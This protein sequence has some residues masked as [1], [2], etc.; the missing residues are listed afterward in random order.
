MQEP[1]GLGQGRPT[2][3]TVRELL[4]RRPYSER[5]CIGF[6]TILSAR[7][8]TGRIS[9]RELYSF[10][11]V[12]RPSSKPFETTLHDMKKILG[13]FNK[14]LILSFTLSLVVNSNL[15]LR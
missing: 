10:P 5:V 1:E 7:K 3:G 8:Y 4:R 11:P 12:Q 2:G 13:K 15:L 6:W 14:P 9:I